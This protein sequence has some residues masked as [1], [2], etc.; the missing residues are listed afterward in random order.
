MLGR[1]MRQLVAEDRGQFRLGVEDP[2]QATGDIDV[3]PGRRGEGVDLLGVDDR[4]R[5]A[6]LQAGRGRHPLPDP[7][8]VGGL[9][10]LIG[11]A[12]LAQELGLLGP[13]A[14]G[15]GGGGEREQRRGDE[16]DAALAHHDR[17]PC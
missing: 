8:H 14:V 15:L 2:Q 3:A 13:D 10:P 5:A 6:A 1:D 17:L 16:G 12:D 11:A 7:R 4:E 9:G